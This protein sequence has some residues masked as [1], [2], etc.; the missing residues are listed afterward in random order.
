M[1]VSIAASRAASFTDERRALHLAMSCVHFVHQQDASLRIIFPHPLT[2]IY[3]LLRDAAH[4]PT[5]RR[6][7]T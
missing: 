6:R 2:L 1:I 3:S 5:Q 4:S 7:K